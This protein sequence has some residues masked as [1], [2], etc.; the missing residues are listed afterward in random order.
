MIEEKTSCRHVIGAAK[1]S[2][3]HSEHRN[4]PPKEHDGAPKPK[5]KISTDQQSILIEADVA[6]V[7]VKKGQT[8]PTPDHVSGAVPDDR[9]A[10]AASTTTTM[11]I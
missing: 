9:T 2:R 7:S 5:K 11:L 10:A 8:K 4:E 1:Q 6:T 3:K